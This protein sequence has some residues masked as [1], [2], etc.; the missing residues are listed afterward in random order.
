MEGL[1]VTEHQGD[2]GAP[3]VAFVHGT[4]DRSTAFIKVQ[5]HLRDVSSVRY[6]RRGYGRSLELGA[7]ASM[8]EQVDDL[9]S[10]LHGR[11]AVVCGHSLGGTIGLALAA[12]HPELV[13]AVL[14]FESPM[15]WNDW[16]PKDTAG[17]AAMDGGDEAAAAERFMRRLVGDE[18]W[19]ALPEPTR[20]QRRA[21][22][23]ALLADLRGVRPPAPPPFELDDVRVPVLAA[24]CSESGPHHQETAKRIALGA[25]VA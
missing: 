19:E 1:F 6:D 14:A 15:P 9:R 3:L 16:W 18:R 8:A 24:H 5:R 10:V 23:P 20:E 7:A 25:P 11:R 12:Q 21:E 2:A 13:R 4:L 22:G 17:G